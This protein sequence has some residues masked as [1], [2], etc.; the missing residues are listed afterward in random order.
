[1]DLLSSLGLV[2]YDNMMHVSQ[3]I[4]RAMIEK[5]L[6]CWCTYICYSVVYWQVNRIV[7]IVIL[8]SV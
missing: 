3:C 6:R 4:T 8:E 7:Y 5:E 1:M 2:W